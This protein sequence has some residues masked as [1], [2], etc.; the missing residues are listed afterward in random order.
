MKAWLKDFLKNLKADLKRLHTSL[1]I[2]FNSVVGSVAL[3]MPEAVSAFPQLQEYVSPEFYK[4]AMVVLLVGNFLLRF[5]TNRP[6][7]DK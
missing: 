5:R 6:L 1:T 4:Q 7:R 3:A 2:W